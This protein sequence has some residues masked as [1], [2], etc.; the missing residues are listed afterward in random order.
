MF[1]IFSQ[2]YQKEK[3]HKL[4]F[5]SLSRLI[6]L[7]RIQKIMNDND[8]K[9]HDEVFFW[10]NLQLVKKAYHLLIHSWRTAN[11]CSFILFT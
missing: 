6:V 10:K 7:Q 2:K 5:D 11:P 3:I 1:Q 4:G 9:S 8:V